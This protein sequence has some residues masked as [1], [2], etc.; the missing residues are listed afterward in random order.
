MGDRG[1]GGDAGAV[2]AAE[3]WPMGVVGEDG[4][5][6]EREGG[7]EEGAHGRRVGFDGCGVNRGRSRIGDSSGGVGVDR[8]LHR[9]KSHDFGYKRRARR[10]GW[11]IYVRGEG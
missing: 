8:Y 1:G 10:I 11:L 4:E 9:P 6:E 5:G 7:E 3:T 2:G